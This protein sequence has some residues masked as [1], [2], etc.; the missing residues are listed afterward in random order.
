MRSRAADTDQAHLRKGTASGSWVRRHAF[1]Y[2][3]SLAVLR[4]NRPTGKQHCSHHQRRAAA[5]HLTSLPY[6]G[7]LNTTPSSCA[8]PHS[9]KILPLHW[10]H[11]KTSLNFCHAKG[12]V[13]TERLPRSGSRVMLLY[14][15]Q[16][17]GAKGE[18]AGRGG[19]ARWQ[20]GWGLGRHATSSRLPTHLYFGQGL[21]VHLHLRRRG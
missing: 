7:E 17:R 9:D 19:R 15:H 3:V 16:R 11:L 2:L 13:S 20:V 21:I 8:C 18:V 4:L 10:M 12:P 14:A 5:V 6:G 1:C